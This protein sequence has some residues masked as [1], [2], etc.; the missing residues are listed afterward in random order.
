MKHQD[1]FEWTEDFDGYIDEYK[2]YINLKMVCS[3]GGAQTRSLREVYHFI[4]AQLNYLKNNINKTKIFFINILDGDESHR[5]MSKF[6]YLI[7][8][9]KYLTIKK[10]IYV[11]NMKNFHHW[12]NTQFAK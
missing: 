9:K 12:F 2:M 1:G 3:S 10:N 6:E 11:G 7:S 5:N 4:N 8:K